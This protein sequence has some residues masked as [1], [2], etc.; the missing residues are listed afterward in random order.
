MIG[1]GYSATLRKQRHVEYSCVGLLNLADL[2]H[3][4]GPGSPR[5]SGFWDALAPHHAAIEN[6]YLD[7]RSIRRLMNVLHEPVLVVGAGQGLIVAE[8]RKSGIPCDGVDFSR[9]MIRYAK[10]R[11]GID[12]IHADAAAMPIPDRCYGTVIYAT[13][14]V[15]FTGDEEQIKRMLEEGKRIVK[16]SGRIH[17]AFYRVSAAT[18][19][20]MIQVGLLRNHVVAQKESF[21]LY[22]LNPAQMIPWIAK[23][24][25]VGYL[26]A[27]FIL[28]R[29]S[30]FA[31]IHERRMTLRMQKIF[32]G[33]KDPSSFINAAS[34]KQPYRNEAEIR[35]LF[36]R[37]AIPVR[38]LETFLSCYVVR[39]Q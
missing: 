34:D 18:E 9:E 28:L 24:A 15:D 21:E 23:K 5:A 12:L 10:L 17:V 20:F 11:R 6:S 8:I 32:R 33:M 30:I 16:E 27:M 25:G 31:T 3:A 37:L 19:R 7:V 26:R 38:Q 4:S 2:P 14:V 29:I 1:I 22:L 39:I 35:N 36:Q 13:G